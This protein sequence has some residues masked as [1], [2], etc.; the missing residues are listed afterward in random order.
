MRRINGLLLGDPVTA[1]EHSTTP[2][3]VSGKAGFASLFTDRWI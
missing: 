2:S 1:F 3:H